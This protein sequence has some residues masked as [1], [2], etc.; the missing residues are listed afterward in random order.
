MWDL[1]GYGPGQ[2]FGPWT[3]AGPLVSAGS[4]VGPRRRSR[5][6]VVRPGRCS[7][8]F[9]RVRPYGVGSQV[10]DGKYACRLGAVSGSEVDQG[11]AAIRE[12]RLHRAPVAPIKGD[13]P[14]A[15]LERHRPRGTV[16]RAAVLP[17]SGP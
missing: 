14:L 8:S 10:R 15:G 12:D 3:G 16:A 2:V 11:L 1:R 7:R 5:L 9:G 13:D 6:A 4:V 17:I